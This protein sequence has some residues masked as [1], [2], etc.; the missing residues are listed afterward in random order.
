MN[1]QV[2]ITIG[3]NDEG[4]ADTPAEIAQKIL[5]ALGGDPEKD[6][7]NVAIN[8]SGSVGSLPAPPPLPG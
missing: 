1:V 5:T 6:M 4:I 3:A 7:A 8:A 2:I